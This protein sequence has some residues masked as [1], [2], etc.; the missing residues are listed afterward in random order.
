[1]LKEL[2]QERSRLDEAIHRGSGFSSLRAKEAQSAILNLKQGD[3]VTDGND[4]AIVTKS[5]SEL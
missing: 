3:R 1:M 5:S 2:Q 4:R